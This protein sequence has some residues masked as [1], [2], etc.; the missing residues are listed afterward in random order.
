MMGASHAATGAAA[1][2]ALT[3]PLADVSGIHVDPQLQLIGALTTAGAA[4]I[5]DW[6]HPR[7]TI[8]YALPPLTNLIAAG[9]RAIAGGHRQGTHSLLAVLAFTALAAA[10]TPLR[11]TL[12][13]QEY[14]I[15]QGVIAAFLVTVAAKAL[16]IIPT[17]GYI[18]A[19]AI[20]LS[21]G[22]LAST[23]APGAWWIPV[24]VALG[25]SMHILGD[26][27]TK[28]GVPLLWPAKPAAPVPNPVWG[29]D[30]RFRLLLVGTTGSW[31]E[32]VLITPITLYIAVAAADLLPAL[33]SAGVDLP[34][35]A[36]WSHP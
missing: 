12:A 14:A 11:A 4:L 29:R 28:E 8:A 1:W 17:S 32:W 3:G 26:G 6:D 10:L 33:I 24:S 7:A 35:V 15:G 2:L 21:I 13:G 31:R 5:S 18:S 9:I 34:L 20:G 23:T 19:W 36:H 16:L 27:L 25:V 22:A 30:G